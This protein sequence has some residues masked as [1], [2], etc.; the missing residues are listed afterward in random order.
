[1]GCLITA[2]V[3]QF[4]AGFLQLRHAQDGTFAE[5]STLR[6]AAWTILTCHAVPN[7]TA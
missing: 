5:V 3:R 4:N 7:K 1:M 6:D 2:V